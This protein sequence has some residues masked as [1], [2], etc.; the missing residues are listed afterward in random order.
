MPYQN[1]NEQGTLFQH[2]KFQAAVPSKYLK[3]NSCKK[4]LILLPQQSW[5]PT[6]CIPRLAPFWTTT[7]S[8]T[9]WWR[10]TVCW[11]RKPN[12]PST[13]KFPSSWS[14]IKIRS[15][16]YRREVTSADSFV[17]LS[18]SGS[19]VK[20][21]VRREGNPRTKFSLFYYLSRLRGATLEVKL[22]D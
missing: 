17:R 5:R 7:A 16:I 21:D 1:S 12:G 4:Y 14:S 8:T 20:R 18:V 11:G 22:G 10:S 3:Y 9:T 2:L 13:R 6:Q 19:G 15:N